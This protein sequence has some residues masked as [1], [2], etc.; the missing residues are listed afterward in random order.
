MKAKI[1]EV[2]HGNHATTDIEAAIR[3][4]EIELADYELKQ[5]MLTL[6]DKR[7]IDANLIDKVIKTLCGIANNGPGRT[8]KLIIGVTDKEADAS[9]VKKLDGVEP[10]KVGKR[11][12]VGVSREAKV[13]DISVEQYVGKW[14]DAIR[15]SKLSNALRDAVLSSLDFNSYFGLGVIVFSI[16]S[17]KEVSFVGDEVY[18]RNGDSTEIATSPKQIADLAKRF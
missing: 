5:G 17:Q 1:G 4:S 8:G 3:R 14:K 2:I 13:L 15:Q 6:G 12:V 9:R 10:K 16:P 18:W 11:F 7:E